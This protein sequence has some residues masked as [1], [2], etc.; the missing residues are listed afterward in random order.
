[1][2]SKAGH[3]WCI[4]HGVAALFQEPNVDGGPAKILTTPRFDEL[5]PAP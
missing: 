1:M 2:G 5:V 3:Q 4:A